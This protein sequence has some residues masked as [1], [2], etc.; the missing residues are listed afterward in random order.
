MGPDAV[1]V[2]RARNQGFWRRSHLLCVRIRPKIVLD[3]GGIEQV[4]IRRQKIGLVFAGWEVVKRNDIHVIWRAL[5]KYF[6]FL[7]KTAIHPLE[8]SGNAKLDQF[9]PV[10]QKARED[11]ASFVAGPESKYEIRERYSIGRSNW[12]NRVC[13]INGWKHTC[14][15]PF[16]NANG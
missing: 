13:G 7:K 14:C 3:F 16:W 5:F 10:F 2:G 6:N 1:P 4:W 11:N 8:S 15:G 9:V 12:R